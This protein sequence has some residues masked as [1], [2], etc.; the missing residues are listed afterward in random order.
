M[1]NS[2][3]LAALVLLFSLLFAACGKM[4]DADAIN[5]LRK[6]D[7]LWIAHGLAA[8]EA[9]KEPEDLSRIF[10]DQNSVDYLTL[11]DHMFAYDE[12]ISRTV[13]EEFFRFVAE[14]HGLA[15]ILDKDMRIA[16]KSEYLRSL[17]LEYDYPQSAEIEAFFRDIEFHS[18]DRYDFIFTHE[19]ASFCFPDLSLTATS[20]YRYFIFYTTDFI[21]KFAEFIQKE[22]LSSYF[23]A[24]RRMA[25]HCE[26][27]GM[28]GY[29]TTS[30]KGYIILRG[31]F[32]V[33][34]HEA[35]HAMANYSPATGANRMLGEGLAEYF[36]KVLDLS[37][38]NRENTFSICRSA[39][40]G[41]YDT[42]AAHGHE[43]AR[44]YI[45]LSK[46]YTAAGGKLDSPESFDAELYAHLAALYD[47]NFGFPD[48]V[49]DA[50]IAINVTNLPPFDGSEL[51]YAESCSFVAWLIDQ[52]DLKTV[53][54]AWQ[55]D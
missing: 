14:K 27:L 31:G 37:T 54:D 6:S 18:D 21:R 52:Y 15:A 20:Q 24:D 38:L 36:T 25:F 53:L 17:G 50:A 34:P 41:L 8:W 46:A 48:S 30:A 42:S 39:A 1:R 11:Y 9:D 3:R 55:K 26:E 40:R 2:L 32:A 35:V 49:L 5:D 22:Q 10:Y 45:A 4:S 13:A 44:L 23:T 47:R 33:A 29:S 16:Y 43:S 51:T 19:A 28:G 12:E 7:E